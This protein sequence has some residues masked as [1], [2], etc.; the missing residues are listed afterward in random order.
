MDQIFCVSFC[1]SDVMRIES[2]QSFH[3]SEAEAWAMYNSRFE[4]VGLDRVM[5]TLTRVELPSMERTCI[6]EFEGR[7]DGL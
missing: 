5:I 3:S 2:S 1:T 7:T 4:E 6:A